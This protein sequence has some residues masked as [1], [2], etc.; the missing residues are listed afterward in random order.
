MQFIYFI[1][2]SNGDMAGRVQV[3]VA[4]WAAVQHG[5]THNRLTAT[6]HAA[7]QW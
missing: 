6:Q 1:F 3:V 7:H 5:K 2:H 4:R